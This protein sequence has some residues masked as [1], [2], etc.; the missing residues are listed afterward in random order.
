[1][2][3]CA[4][5]VVAAP[6]EPRIVTA[7]SSHGN[8]AIP[9][10][11]G[12]LDRRAN[13]RGQA[14]YAVHVHG[15][16]S[17]LNGGDESTAR[18][19]WDFG[20][21]GSPYNTLVGWNAAHIYDSPGLYTL[22]LRVTNSLRETSTK[23]IP[24]L[25]IPAA[26]TPIH[27]SP[28]GDDLNDGLTP[29]TAVR[30]LARVEGMIHDNT[31]VCL[32]RGGVY[33]TEWGVAT[34]SRNVLITAYGQGADPVIRFDNP[35]PY[36]KMIYVTTQARNVVIENITFDSPFTL[37]DSIVGAIEVH[38]VNTT[39][40]N[41]RFG[42]VS[43]AITTGGGAASGA[44]GLL[45]QNNKCGAIGAYFLWIEGADQTHLGNVVGD[46][47]EQHNIRLGGARRI[48]IAHNDLTCTHKS[49]IWCML[50]DHCYVAGNR[51]R[52]GRFIVGPN[53]VLTD[54]QER[55]LWA[56][57]ENNELFNAQAEIH[58]GAEQVTLRNNIIHADGFEAISVWGFDPVRN[59]T[60]R[61]VTLA[62]NTAINLDSNYGRFL[63]IGAGAV[64][65]AVRNNL[66]DAPSLNGIFGGNVFCDDPTLA[67]HVFESNIWS[68]P[69]VGSRCHQ[70]GL[71]PL[72][73]LG[74]DAL[75]ETDGEVH[76]TFSSADLSPAYLPNFHANIAQPTP[77]VFTDFQ[78]DARPPRAPWKAGAVE[79]GSPFWTI[80]DLNRDS[81]VNTDD[82]L[83]VVTAW[84][85]CSG[86]PGDANGD[87]VVN[88][89][90]L[91]LVIGDWT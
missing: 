34:D 56:V 22:T 57:F 14:P 37:S 84:G 85:A 64:G 52:Q 16:Q 50:G 32:Q 5:S 89:D 44:Y 69:I 39:V 65:V 48:L 11:Q 47:I 74:W 35:T 21:P 6:P 31:M 62:N 45:T 66:Y 1:M 25:V 51:L 70:L 88:V 24:V 76:R 73:A 17:I 53:F 68:L 9:Q 71:D 61:S 20:D 55:F 33:P 4:A 77:G 46:S 10:F 67:S 23:S 28:T 27:V 54:P 38:G 58:D 87:G 29:A 90:D 81:R 72:D 3:G 79:V 13:L 2:F 36:L 41:C 86:C 12:S 43:Y 7:A 63:G 26:R 8:V 83:L 15:L 40:R 80:G 49:T 91:L 78:G 30:S 82:L 42:N 19:E 75:P 59:R 18:F 60:T